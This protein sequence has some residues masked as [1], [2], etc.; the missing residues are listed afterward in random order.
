MESVC[1]R[2]GLR[3]IEVQTVDGVQQMFLNGK[4]L[5]IKGVNRHETDPVKGRALGDQ[6]IITDLKLMKAYNINAFRTSHYPNHPLTYDVADELG[7]IVVDEA[8]IE[9]HIGD[10]P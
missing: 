1:Q 2:I 8:N 6:E 5:M 10:S 7:L 9:S 3:E 4:P